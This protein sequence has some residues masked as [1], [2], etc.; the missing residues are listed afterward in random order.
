MSTTTITI[1]TAAMTTTTWSDEWNNMQGM[2]GGAWIYTA[3]EYDDGTTLLRNAAEAADG[4]LVK[5]EISQAG[6]P[7]RRDLRDV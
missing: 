7:T 1:N 2:T 4:Y 3:P 6:W 5:K